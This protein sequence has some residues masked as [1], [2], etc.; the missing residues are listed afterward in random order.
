MKNQVLIALFMLCS[1]IAVS[2]CPNSEIIIDDFTGN[3]CGV[4]MPEAMP[5]GSAINKDCSTDNSSIVDSI[6]I[7]SLKQTNNFSASRITFNTG[8]LQFEQ[9]E[10][11]VGKTC[12][13]Y[14]Y[15]TGNSS[16]T[17]PIITGPVLANFTNRTVKLWGIIDEITAINTVTFKCI[18]W[19]ALGEKSEATNVLVGPRQMS[20]HVEEISLGVIVGSANLND[21]RAIQFLV[22]ATQPGLDLRLDKLEAS[23]LSVLSNNTFKST[24]TNITNNQIQISWQTQSANDISNFEVE[25]SSNSLGFTKIGQVAT[26]NQ[27]N[28]NYVFNHKPNAA[29]AYYRVVKNMQNGGKVYSNIIKYIRSTE[30]DILVSAFAAYGNVNVTVNSSKRQEV[31]FKILNQNGQE[32]Q[33]E[34]QRLNKGQNTLILKNN[35]QLPKGLYIVTMHNGATIKSIRYLQQ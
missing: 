29:A 22:E 19:D 13:T 31:L 11:Y 23:C 5:Y 1:L 35:M 16:T 32:L 17:L 3:R 28:H 10:D 4:T 7:M 25:E 12:I 14:D 27:L 24:L 33:Q 15:G 6:N 26:G 8:Y 34:K 2:Q 30:D 18:F 21:I 20:L 9:D